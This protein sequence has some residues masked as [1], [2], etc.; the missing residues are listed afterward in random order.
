MLRKSW[1]IENGKR[2]LLKGGYKNEIL[3]PFNEVLAS[4]ICD[5]LG[6]NHVSYKLDIIKDKIVSKCECFIN[7]DTNTS[8]SNSS[9][10]YKR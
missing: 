10:S 5:K 4:M 1:I 8:L 3:Q 9:W 2:V 7:K 6:F